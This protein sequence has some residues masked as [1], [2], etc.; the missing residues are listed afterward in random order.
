MNIQKNNILQLKLSNGEEI[1]C[2]IIEVPEEVDEEVD[3]EY[4]VVVRNCLSISKVQVSNNKIFCMLKPWLSFQDMDDNNLA[5]LNPQHIIVRCIP[6]DDI[7]TQYLSAINHCEDETS[8][9]TA[10]GDDY[11]DASNWM[12][13]LGL[14][15][16][17]TIEMYD[18]D[19]NIINF[20][21][22]VQ[23]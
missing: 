12:D 11:L 5:S 13:R 8:N 10:F 19:E 17:D 14:G 20:P 2:E 9:G 23:H 1:L 18:S 22:G 3:E 7:M 15:K 21:K 6:N 16:S 4:E